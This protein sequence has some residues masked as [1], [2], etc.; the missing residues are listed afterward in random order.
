MAHLEF[1]QIAEYLLAYLHIGPRGV[2]GSLWSFLPA[3]G[4]NRVVPG[5]ISLHTA[6]RIGLDSLR[7]VLQTQWEFTLRPIC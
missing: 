2:I 6:E 5:G 3:L 1:G 4:L 7:A